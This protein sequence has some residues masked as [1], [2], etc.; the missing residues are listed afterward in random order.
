MHGL[1][2][3]I[4][5][6][7]VFEFYATFGVVIMLGWCGEILATGWRS[8]LRRYVVFDSAVLGPVPSNI[9]QEGRPI[10][11]RNPSN[12]SL[13]DYFRLSYILLLHLRGRSYPELLARPR[14]VR[15]CQFLWILLSNDIKLL[16]QTSVSH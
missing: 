1:W 10:G 3:C 11:R 14:V 4:H 13:R 7:T 8:L 16:L 5:V 12:N 9:I 15:S 2:W 6:R